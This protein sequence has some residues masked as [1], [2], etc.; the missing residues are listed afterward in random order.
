MPS[1]RTRPPLTL[2]G[3]S[4]ALGLFLAGAAL[5]AWAGSPPNGTPAQERSRLTG[6]FQRLD[7]DH[8][9]VLSQA[10][11]G[12]EAADPVQSQREFQEMDRTH[13]GYVTLDEFLEYF[14]RGAAHGAAPAK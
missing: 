3:L 1:R 5:P 9:G 11:M 12:K 7:S 4:L 6:E 2:L 10:E 8:D 13:R 14:D